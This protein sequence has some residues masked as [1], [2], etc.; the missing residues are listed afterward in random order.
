MIAN[1]RHRMEAAIQNNISVKEK[2][3]NMENN[4][5]YLR[6]AD[7]AEMMQVSIPKAYSLMR[8]CNEE[9]KKKGYLVVSGRV[10]RQYFEERTMYGRD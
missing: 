9:L 2:G 5:K 7:V 4:K 3:N 1:S 10:S 8:I 6:A